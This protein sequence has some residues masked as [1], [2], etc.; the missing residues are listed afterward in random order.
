MP[1]IFSISDCSDSKT[2]LI[3][4]SR[5]CLELYCRSVSFMNLVLRHVLLVGPKQSAFF[6]CYEVYVVSWMGG[7][8]V[9]VVKVRR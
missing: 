3:I 6:L 9:I 7:L 8:Y 2:T 1:N 4:V 5:C